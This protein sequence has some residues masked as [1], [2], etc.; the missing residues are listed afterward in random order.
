[1]SV[2]QKTIARLRIFLKYREL[3]FQLV[4]RAIK[5]K[6]RRSVLGYIWSVLNPLLI[7][8][9][10]TVVFS[11]LFA[12]GVQN[13]P[14][15][16]LIGHI[17]FSF[18][19][20]AT[21]MALGSV[22][23]NAALLKKIY[24][25]KYIFTLAAVTSELVI[26]IFTLGALIIVILVTKTP[27]TARFIFNIIPIA[28]QYVFCIGLGLFLAQAVVFFRDVV[29]IWG[30]VTTAWLYLSAIFYP[31]TSLPDNLRFFIARYNPMYFYIT[32]FRNFTIGTADMGSMDLAI[33]G[34]VAAALMLFLG[35]V[36]F[37]YSK[38]KFILYM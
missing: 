27:L 6:Y 21:S 1:M 11:T 16:L 34:A 4:S 26:F 36:S 25:P 10:M 37:S 18:M 31:V 38:N 33:R 23:G 7:M 28:E 14:I 24:I 9:V 19:T 20:G 12:R 22:I 5:L 3:F 29:H 30:V 15:Y 17:L 32:M 13:F 2:L 8:A 35:L